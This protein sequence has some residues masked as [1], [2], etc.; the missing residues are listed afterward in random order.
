MIKPD[1]PK[2]LVINLLPRSTC[3]IQVASVIA[4]DVGIF[5]WGWNSMGPTGMGLCAER[6]AI[7]RAKRARLWKATIYVAGGYKG[8]SKMVNSKP[9]AKCQSVIDQYGMTVIYRNQKG[10]WK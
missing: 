5:A 1:D 6:H 7:K 9:C 2:D 3:H 4:D 10:E 8:R